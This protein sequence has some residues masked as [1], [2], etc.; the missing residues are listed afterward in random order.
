VAEASP[1]VP[2][3]RKSTGQFKRRTPSGMAMPEAPPRRS[4]ASVPAQQ[5]AL[6]ASSDNLSQLV[7]VKAMRARQ[8]SRL[9]ALVAV[10]ALAGMLVLVLVF[11]DEILSVLDRDGLS[12]DGVPLRL[13]VITNPPTFVTVIPP[14]GVKN[15]QPLELGR[16]PITEQSGAFVGD[17][18]VLTNEDRGIH[19]E[20]V[21]EYG[22]PNELKVIEQEFKESTVKIRVKPP[23]KG[24]T[25]WRGSTRLGQANIPF[26]MY[27]GV[28]QLEVHA[29]RL[30]EPFPFELRFSPGQRIVEQ[31]VDVSAALEKSPP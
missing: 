4:K 30:P 24:A 8:H 3:R 20:T 25:I 9:K 17:T 1:A 31:E 6:D 27:P 23:L 10:L 29:D 19:F 14:R 26:G 5:H 21:L 15:R 22:Q 12:E 13:S 2:P 11:K 16:T 18:V 28:H 7:D